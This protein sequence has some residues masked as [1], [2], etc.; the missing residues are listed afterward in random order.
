MFTPGAIRAFGTGTVRITTGTEGIDND[1]VT[2]TLEKE[3][4]PFDLPC[5]LG[6]NYPGPSS[7]PL[8]DVAGNPGG[9]G[10]FFEADPFTNEFPAH[11]APQGEVWSG[12]LTV[13]DIG[14][15]GC[16]NLSDTELVPDRR[17]RKR[18]RLRLIWSH[19]RCHD[20][21][22]QSICPAQVL[23]ISHWTRVFPRSTRFMS[24]GVCSP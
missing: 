1:T 8:Q 11:E 15:L 10:K 9:V 5:L 23:W 12:T 7:N 21:H 22:A 18:T 16:A 14:G 24:V 13:R 3:F 20:S 4:G 17:L 6:F 2:V 19:R